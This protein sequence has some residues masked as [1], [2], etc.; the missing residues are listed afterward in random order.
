L[1]KTL[2][3]EFS[4][5]VEKIW[6]G[7]DYLIGNKLGY[8]KVDIVGTIQKVLVWVVEKIQNLITDYIS[9]WLGD[10]AGYVLGGL[11]DM[12]TGTNYLDTIKYSKDRQLGIIETEERNKS[13]NQQ[14]RDIAPRSKEDIEQNINE[15]MLRELKYGKQ[16]VNDIEKGDKIV[17]QESNRIKDR[18]I[19]F[20][21]EIETKNKQIS[22][23][24]KQNIV[25]P[26]VNNKRTN[27]TTNVISQNIIPYNRDETLRNITMH[28]SCLQ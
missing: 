9:G 20:E 23:L 17:I 3:D 18:N 2:G 13:M 21:K 5:L 6:N 19:L 27:N 22:K 28:Q 25:A 10:W 4:W 1:L 12:L 24:S 8:I 11:L 14:L 7:I 26:I 15:N 16:E